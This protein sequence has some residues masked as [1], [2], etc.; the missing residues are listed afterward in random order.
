VSQEISADENERFRDVIVRSLDLDVEDY[1]IN[2]HPLEQKVADGLFN[3]LSGIT[4]KLREA[5]KQGKPKPEIDALR[6]RFLTI[7]QY[8]CMSASH[9]IL[10]AEPLPDYLDK[11]EIWKLFYSTTSVPKPDKVTLTRMV[12]YV[13]ELHKSWNEKKKE[14]KVYQELP[15]ESRD[16]KAK[17]TMLVWR[18]DDWEKKGFPL[19]TCKLSHREEKGFLTLLSV[20]LKRAEAKESIARI[21]AYA[22][23]RARSQRSSE[24]EEC[25]SKEQRNPK[26]QPTMPVESR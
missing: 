23:V 6:A 2:V 10:I 21:Y 1:S 9:F 24:A 25:R 19:L 12:Q 18:S 16:P 15:K 17:P 22:A 14:S 5:R 20:M 26:E 11:K 7:L 13:Y 4:R 8:G 3:Q